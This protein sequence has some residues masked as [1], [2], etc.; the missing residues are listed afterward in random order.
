M[1]SK[2]K[3]LYRYMFSYKNCTNKKR[4]NFLLFKIQQKL[5][6]SH[7]ISYPIELC[8]DPGNICNLRCPLCP[9]GKGDK[10]RKKGF[11]TLNTFKKIID[12]IGDYLYDIILYN[13][14]E[15]LLNQQ[16]F[17]MIKY[18]KEKNI[19]VEISSN[20]NHFNDRM[21]YKMIKS[22][23]DTLLVSLVG[24][25]QESVSK[26]QIGSNFALVI[27]NMKKLVGMKK[28]LN[29]KLPYIQWRF[30]VNK[31]NES[32]IKKAKIIAEE[33][34][35]DRLEIGIFR[36]NMEKELFMDN[37][38]QFNDVK[39]WLPKNEILS[40]YDYTKKEK[41]NKHRYCGWLWEN[42]VINWDGSVSPC[43]A[44]WQEKYD[45]GNIHDMPFFEIWNNKKYQDARKIIR[46]DKIVRPDNICYIC[47]LNNAQI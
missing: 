12:E 41:K 37:E 17:E 9:T 29:S 3:T 35:V 16:I 11:M 14:G 25:S 21:C 36:C 20:F 26:Y 31:Y 18:A 32:E 5:K 24:A 15:P 19:K 39:D 45:F 8:I 23:L 22:G 28:E 30:L 33:I 13:W 47:K 1:I 10:D 42:S 38:A 7:V 27:N 6:N 4:L 2:L 44:V 46:G 43:C 40:M 34:G